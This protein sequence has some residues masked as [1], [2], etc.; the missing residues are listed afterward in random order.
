MVSDIKERVVL[1]SL[2]FLVSLLFILSAEVELGNLSLPI[3][4]SVNPTSQ[5]TDGVTPSGS[6]LRSSLIPYSDIQYSGALPLYIQTVQDKVPAQLDLFKAYSQAS[7]SS[8]A[9]ANSETPGFTG[10]SF[11][12]A[13]RAE[14]GRFLAMV[15]AES[16][17]L[18]LF[19]E[20]L[21]SPLFGLLALLFFLVISWRGCLITAAVLLAG[22][23]MFRFEQYRAARMRELNQALAAS[24]ELTEQLTVQQ[25]ELGK[26][27]RTL[28][29]DYAVIRALNESPTPQEAA[30]HI[31]Q[32]ICVSTGWDSGAI[33]DVD[34]QLA[35]PVCVGVWQKEFT[36]APAVAGENRENIFSSPTGLLRR[37][38]TRREPQWI[39][40][41]SSPT[42]FSRLT[43]AQEAPLQ[44]AFGFPIFS[45]PELV[46][47]LEFYSR[48]RRQP[49]PELAQMLTTIASHIGQLIQR[50]RAE[51]ALNK[52]QNEHLLELQRVRRRI[53][54]DLHD[55]VGSSLTKIALISETVRQTVAATNPEACERLA[56]LAT[57]SNELVE[58]MSDIVWAINPRN[59]RLSTLAQRM[60][61]YASDIFTARKIRFRFQPPCTDAVL[62]ANLRR[63][64]FLIF[65]ESVNN[66]IKHSQCSE[67]VCD[68][69]VHQEKLT[70]NISD[71]GKGIDPQILKA[72]TGYLTSNLQGGNGLSNMRRRARELGGQFEIM[73]SKARGTTVSL[74]LPFVYGLS[75]G[76]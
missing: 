41:L 29:L 8:H 42:T 24:E 28:A 18:P 76:K 3:S 2:I 48:D 14:A 60:R 5:A 66:V 35:K 71:N 38:L 39:T 75:V 54:N 27:Y 12:Q 45:G 25:M 34:E 10:Q 4:P 55:D 67:V 9:A 57:I 36:D 68:L 19:T 43:M 51:E 73:T 44:S 26:A 15:G 70:F 23:A 37:L 40:H 22:F 11:L 65:K 50:R 6:A 47:A 58:T 74:K 21:V 69:A 16:L 62:G 7:E 20:S 1:H 49:D 52:S 61:R 17:I 56:T 13:L 53:A 31:L 72:D 63:E 46:G 30:G 59:D 64:V 33:W 32:T